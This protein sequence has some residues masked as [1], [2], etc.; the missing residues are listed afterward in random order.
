M[1]HLELLDPNRAPAT[2]T[3]AGGDKDG[4]TDEDDAPDPME[5]YERFITARVGGGS[6]AAAG[7]ERG[8]CPSARQ[9]GGR[10]LV[11]ALL[12]A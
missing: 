11:I 12:L 2:A 7:E 8:G 9:P 1:S 5:A 3:T 6:A 4:D 10:Q